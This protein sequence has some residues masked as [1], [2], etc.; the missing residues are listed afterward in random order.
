MFTTLSI[1][2]NGHIFSLAFAIMEEEIASSWSWFLHALDEYVTD[3]D[4]LSLI[5]DR[6]RDIQSAINNKEVG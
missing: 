5:F 6:H 3:R 4:G 1:D 2:A